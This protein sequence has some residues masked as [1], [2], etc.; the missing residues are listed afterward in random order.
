MEI[1]SS[2]VD[3]AL[4]FASANLVKTLFSSFSTLSTESMVALSRLRLE[5]QNEFLENENISFVRQETSV[6]SHRKS[7]EK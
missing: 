5:K 2:I 4:H 7:T 1:I 6:M 3:E